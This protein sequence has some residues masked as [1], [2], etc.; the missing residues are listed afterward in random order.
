M[1]GGPGAP[2]AILAAMV[3]EPVPASSR[4]ASA[5]L[6]ARLGLVAL[7]SS[8]CSKASDEKPPPRP[9]DPAPAV[10]PPATAEQPPAREQWYRMALA[11]S[12][13]PEIPLFLQLPPRGSDARGKVV[14]GAQETELD[15]AWAGDKVTLTVPIMHASV[16]ATAGAD[17]A[18]AGTWEVDSKSW[19]QSSM[20][21]KAVPIAEP[22]PETRFDEAMLPGAPIDLGENR[23]V[24]RASF[25]ESNVAKVVLQQVKPGVFEATAFFSTGNTVFLAGNGRGR[26]ILMSS[27]VGFSINL[28]RGELDSDSKTLRGTWISGPTLAWREKFE[29]TRVPDFEV[30]VAVKRKGKGDILSMPQLKS[31]AGKPLIVE[32][33]GSWCDACKHAAT[34]LR[35]VYASHHASGLEIVSLSY[36]FTDDSA[37]NA[38]QAAAFKKEYSIPWEV[39]P[40][41]GGAERAWEIIPPGVEEVDASG[42]PLTFFVNRDGSVHA[43]HVSFAGPEAPEEHRR[44]VEE[45]RKGA[46]AI[47]EAKGASR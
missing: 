41:D 8:A 10:T 28:F 39:V 43:M 44:D 7:L 27:L 23:T 38:Q 35:D 26:Q 19:G 4:R 30:E 42:F 17:G 16:V 21:F 3:P 46:A 25:S 31:Y 2:I 18:L 5:A 36:E 9:G 47:V 1:R 6:L 24:W 40:V 37:Y 20:P 14:S 13:L 29:A 45:Y 32:V 15:V 33:G 22:A 34:A 11:P 12:D